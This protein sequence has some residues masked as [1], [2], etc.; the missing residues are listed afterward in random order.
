[1]LLTALHKV[2]PRKSG[3]QDLNFVRILKWT[4]LLFFMTFL[5]RV[6][7]QE[8][9][10]KIT[11]SE[12]NVSLKK[13]FTD[14]SKQTGISVMYDE[15]LIQSLGPV[16]IN[17]K[18]ALLKDVLRE[19]LKDKP[20]EFKIEGNTVAIAK[21]KVVAVSVQDVPQERVYASLHGRVTD[22]NGKPLEGVTVNVILNGS[23]NIFA[24]GTNGEF[25]IGGMPDRG[26]IVFSSIGYETKEINY[27]H[28][29]EFN[30]V[31]RKKVTQLGNVT[32]E[33]NN[34]YQILPRERT[35]GSFDIVDSA[36]FNRSVSP[37]FLT[38]LDGVA[39]GVNFDNRQQ[40]AVNS[41]VG[42]GRTETFYIRGLSTINASNYPLIIIDGFPYTS[43]N[44][45]IQDIHNINPNDIESMTVL[46]DAAAA[47]IWG[48]WSSPP[49]PANTAKSRRSTSIPLSPSP[50]SPGFSPSGSSPPPTISAWKRTCM[51]RALTQLCWIPLRRRAILSATWSAC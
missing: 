28:R 41:Y 13:V 32:V 42:Q 14:I 31:L 46:K 21:K 45:Y 20:L 29:S 3:K 38:H 1:M 44:N 11:L 25:S 50:E 12:K 37:N 47:S 9:S 51:R 15:A 17:V 19:C 33:V 35:T 6:K 30:V 5:S 48:S 4:P 34:G 2:F 27:N 7:A 36:L 49:N 10:S 24:T 26:T 16:S 39:S 22:E 8:A 23:G 18:N 40:G 43:D